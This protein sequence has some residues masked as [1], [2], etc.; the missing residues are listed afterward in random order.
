G[1]PEWV[2]LGVQYAD[3]AVWQRELLGGED[4]PDSVLNRQLGFWRKALDG[5]PQ[6]LVLPFDRPRPAVASHRG[7]RVE[8]RVPAEVHARVAELAR[9]EGVTVFMVLQA[10]LAVLLCRVGAGQDIPVGTPVA[11][12]T[13]ETLDE[14]VGF[15]VNTLVMRTDLSGDPSFTALLG[16]VREN[17]L[18]AF[19]HQDVPFERLVE[20]L[21]PVRSMARHPLFQVMLALQN[22]AEAVLDLP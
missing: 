4:D 21:A 19:A 20:D 22:T 1:V 7:G 17:G 12:R 11:G 2:P 16:Q 13:D 6:E 8:V 10:A 9:A 18:A 5:I 15:F 14:L 3:Y